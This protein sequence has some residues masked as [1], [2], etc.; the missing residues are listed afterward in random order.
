MLRMIPLLIL[1]CVLNVPAA[2]PAAPIHRAATSGDLDELDR[3]LASGV[4]VDLPHEV[5]GLTPW[6]MASMHGRAEAEDLLAKAGAD[7]KRPFPEPAEVID[8]ALKGVTATGPGF[9]ILVARDGKV[10]YERGVGMADLKENKPITPQT[11]FRI[12]SVTKQFAAA[13]ILIAEQDGKLEV[14]DTL[15]KYYPGFPRGDKITLHHLLTHTSGIHSF[16]STPGFMEQVTKPAIPESLI[17]SFRDLPPDFAPG[18]SHMYCN[19]GYVLLGEIAGKVEGMPYYELLRTRVFTKEGMSH[20]GAHRPELD[21][22]EQAR[23][24]SEGNAKGSWK[25][26]RDWHMSQAAGAGEIYS[27][28]GDL[29]RWNEALFAGRVLS[30]ESLKK[31]HTPLKDRA[32]APKDG[33]GETYAYGWVVGER[34]GLRSI[35]HNGGLDGFTSE[36]RR[37]PDQNLTVVVLSN[38]AHAIGGFQ[39]SGLADLAA[40]QFL[41]REMKPQPSYRAQKLAEGTK[42][43]DYV[44]TFDLSTL[45]VMRFRIERGKLRCKLAAQQWGNI[46]PDGKDVFVEPDVDARFVFHRDAK[47]KVTSLELKQ[48]GTVL[49]GARFEEAKEGT[50]TRAHLQELAG[51]YQFGLT[52]FNIRVHPRSL[53]LLGK[54]GE[55]PEFAYH[56]V[57]GAPD[58]VFCKSIRVELEF[59]RDKDG[60]VNEFVLHQNGLMLAGQKMKAGAE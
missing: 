22:P 38:S 45:G 42:L 13:A 19:S 4:Q 11:I 1:L 10:L 23:G 59:K 15:D 16:T 54:L 32:D 29:F 2:L 57:L 52:S 5:S 30:P 36:L 51:S 44:G 28:V 48:Y 47:G 31:A 26:A 24:Y 55:Q 39:V 14:T 60:K 6:Q 9:A 20:T 33:K 34:R 37:F 3:I 8:R 35:W 46:A 40:R 17:A 43:E 50:A 27:T 21:L 25:P 49:K 58:R 18:A 56:P 12:G 53:T 41:W 7:I